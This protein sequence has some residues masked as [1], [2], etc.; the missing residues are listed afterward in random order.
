MD[1]KWFLSVQ[2]RVVKSG[3]KV[4]SGLGYVYLDVNSFGLAASWLPSVFLEL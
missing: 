4:G 3:L 1:G 2:A